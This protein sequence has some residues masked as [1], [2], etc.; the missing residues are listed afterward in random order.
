MDFIRYLSPSLLAWMR[1]ALTGIIGLT[2]LAVLRYGGGNAARGEN[3]A[4]NRTLQGGRR[5]TTQ[6]SHGLTKSLSKNFPLTKRDNPTAQGV[7]AALP[8]INRMVISLTSALLQ[9]GGTSSTISSLHLSVAEIIKELCYIVPEVYLVCQVASDQEAEAITTSFKAADL[10]SVGSSLSPGLVPAQRLLLCS[11]S[12]GKVAIV[13]QLEPDLYID[14]DPAA[15][16]ELS[17]FL[18]RVWSIGSGAGSQSQS[19]AE[20]K[21]APTLAAHFK[22]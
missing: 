6:A 15:V 14:S 17:R 1:P 11:K 12:E 13:R 3:A 5:E 16:A 19:K 21:Y 4:N 7:L 22:L 20:C 18:P 10:L 2:I 9:P 8:N